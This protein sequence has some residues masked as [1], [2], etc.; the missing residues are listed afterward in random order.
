MRVCKNCGSQIGENE[1]VCNVCSSN[2]IIENEIK[3]A[4]NLHVE[5]DQK[6]FEKEFFKKAKNMQEESENS[7]PE[8]KYFSTP[9]RF[10]RNLCF[11]LK[12]TLSPIILALLSAVCSYGVMFFNG[13]RLMYEFT[14]NESLR[15]SSVFMLIIFAFFLTIFA[16]LLFLSIYLNIKKL[17]K[18]RNK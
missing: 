16:L 13:R 10:Y 11:Y 14:E 6:L 15:Q 4:N 8:S 9:I 3:E 17:I 18:K 7:K 5:E 12:F 1:E 2:E